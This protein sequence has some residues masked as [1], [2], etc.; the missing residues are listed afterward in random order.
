M[1]VNDAIAVCLSVVLVVANAGLAVQ[2]NETLVTNG[3][4]AQWKSGLPVGWKVGPGASTGNSNR[5]VKSIV[6]KGDGP[7]LQLQG[8]SNCNDWQ[9]VSQLVALEKNRRYVLQFEA[10]TQGLKHEQGQFDNCFVGIFLQDARGR[11]LQKHYVHLGETGKRQFVL[12]FKTDEQT[13]LGQ[14]SVF[15]SKTGQLNVGSVEINEITLA[16]SFDILVADMDRNYSHFTHKKIN[17]Q[18]L[19]EKYRD[20][21][22]TAKTAQQWVDVVADMLAEMNDTHTWMIHNGK[23]ITK[24]KTG[25]VPNFDFSVV[26]DDLQDIRSFGNVGL[27]AKTSDGLGYV[28]ITSLVD[29]DRRT[30]SEVI[31]AVEKLFSTPGIIFDLRRNAGGD[32]T[33][34]QQIA[35]M[36]TEEQIVYAVNKFRSG[37]GHDDFYQHPRILVPG[38]GP[39]YGKKMVCLIGPATVS[40][41]EGFALMMRA[42]PNCTCIGKPTRGASGNPAPVHLAEGIDVWYSRWMALTPE[43]EPIEDVGVQPDEDIQHMRGSDATY[44]RAKELLKQ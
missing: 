41:A 10:S 5:R 31:R 14:I 6:K 12:P 38:K 9:F 27:V 29:V 8:K 34:A 33:F 28:R 37:P 32:E 11:D 3:T 23:Q 2:K 24:T 30:R 19:T 7:S 20:R 43:G 1:R 13:K 15:L 40:S 21:A 17:W 16:D 25:W 36:L 42:L 22:I 39:K 44:A 4:F 35:G 26:D 18:E